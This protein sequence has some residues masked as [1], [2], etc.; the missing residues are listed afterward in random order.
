[1]NYR[2]LSLGTFERSDLDRAL[3]LLIEKKG[4]DL[5]LVPGSPPVFRLDGKLTVLPEFDFPVHADHLSE[6]F[7]SILSDRAKEVL[8][9][10]KQV[11][12]RYEND[13]GRFRANIFRELRGLA[14]VFRAIPL[15]IPTPEELFLPQ[16]VV[17][18][19]EAKS[20]LVLVVGATGSGKSTTLASL[21]NYTNRTKSCRII[22]I[23]DP[24]EFVHSPDKA[25]ISHRELGD[26]VPSFAA[27]LRSAL[28]ED[29]DVIL[30]GEMRDL[31]TMA[32]AIEAALTGHLVFATVH[33]RSVTQTVS[34]IVKVFPPQ[35]Q[36]RIQVTLADCLLGVVYQEL[37]P[38]IGGGRIA[39]FEILRMSPAAAE[40][41][42]QGAFKQ[43]SSIQ[44]AMGYFSLESSL[45][46]RMRKGLIEESLVRKILA[47]QEGARL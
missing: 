45:K 23:E 28:R 18:F 31:E 22:T 32:L 16:E 21:I 42:R 7:S 10:E 39:V 43:I 2:E 30:V 26:H 8:Q 19:A 46:E 24:V 9:R 20:G 13:T 37:L 33:A 35:E 27:G 40:I 41:I 4:S 12:F 14:G 15:K 44:P 1:M 5:H 11:D 34:R 47:R 25:L 38:R 3:T 36:E 6:V 29:P 17:G